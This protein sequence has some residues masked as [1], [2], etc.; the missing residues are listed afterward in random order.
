MLCGSLFAI[1]LQGALPYPRK[2]SKNPFITFPPS[3]T[4]LL[5]SKFL[6]S[7]IN[8]FFSFLFASSSLLSLGSASIPVVDEMRFPPKNPGMKIANV[9]D[10]VVVVVVAV[11]ALVVAGVV[12]LCS[13]EISVTK[14]VVVG[15]SSDMCPNCVTGWA[16]LVI[17]SWE[18]FFVYND[19]YDDARA[20]ICFNTIGT[21]GSPM[22]P[23]RVTAI[24]NS[25]TDWLGGAT[26]SERLTVSSSSE[27]GA[28][29]SMP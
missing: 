23:V 11:S 19:A 21:V 1:Y 7:S 14:S 18:H 20:L 5:K 4:K 3:S 15:N 29:V 10:C 2:R 8:P 13:S 22:M 28:G 16:V 17:S 26:S 9:V 12:L 25:A 24:A 6:I 27:G